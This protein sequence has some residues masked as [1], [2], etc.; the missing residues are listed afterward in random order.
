MYQNI[1]NS[2]K[3][4]APVATDLCNNSLN[5]ENLRNKEEIENLYSKPKSLSCLFTVP[6]N[7]PVQVENESLRGRG[8]LTPEYSIYDRVPQPMRTGGGSYN[9]INGSSGNAEDHNIYDKPTGR[10][11]KSAN[12]ICTGT[13]VEP[14]FNQS[15]TQDAIYDKPISSKNKGV[16]MGKTSVEPSD[17][18]NDIYDRPRKRNKKKATKDNTPVPSYSNF[19]CLSRDLKIIVDE[20]NED[21]D[22]PSK[23]SK[24]IDFVSEGNYSIYDKPVRC[25]ASTPILDCENITVIPV[26]DAI[27]AKPNSTPRLARTKQA[28]DEKTCLSEI[29]SKDDPSIEKENKLPHSK[30]ARDYE[31]KE[32]S[33]ISQPVATSKEHEANAE[34]PTQLHETD[35]K[36]HVSIVSAVEPDNDSKHNKS[37]SR[38]MKEQG[39]AENGP[40][41]EDEVSQDK[42]SNG[43]STCIHWRDSDIIDVKN[44]KDSVMHRQDE[45]VEN[46]GM[47]RNS[48]L[49]SKGNEEK[50]EK[51]VK[52]NLDGI[53]ETN[54]SSSTRVLD[55]NIEN[56]GILMTSDSNLKQD[57]KTS[58]TPLVEP[59]FKGD[60]ESNMNNIASSNDS[61]E[62]DVI[63]NTTQEEGANCEE[64][65][66]DEPT[67]QN[68]KDAPK[69]TI[70]R[71][72]SFSK[73]LLHKLA[74]RSSLKG[75][76]KENDESPPVP[77]E[78]A[79]DYLFLRKKVSR[80]CVCARCSNIS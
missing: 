74:S 42:I 57:T 12:N 24:S 14:R 68:E 27:Y 73:K 30:I 26:N 2:R 71:S 7:S 3:N 23:K 76:E 50:S 46:A 80:Y 18:A 43:S 4:S 9:A 16:K 78:R 56:S 60:N 51:K 35:K 55:T 36:Q 17:E 15:D 5:T 40:Y 49:S 44:G 72:T 19:D 47:E 52:E 53:L 79:T 48:K 75:E 20:S 58:S 8:H 32:K 25:I 63:E 77:V 64:I 29:S 41:V 65:K 66:N 67:K 54:L 22:E 1:K 39:Q 21:A 11:F 34:S 70:R 13:G 6:N 37:A 38:E 61:S 59:T 69:K 62:R 45:Q 28:N 33:N 10:L 31:L